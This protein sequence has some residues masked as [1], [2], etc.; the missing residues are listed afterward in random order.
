MANAALQSARELRGTADRQGVLARWRAKAKKRFFFFFHKVILKLLLVV[1]L[2]LPSS[3]SVVAMPAAS[4]SSQSDVSV[5]AAAIARKA[6]EP[7]S[8]WSTAMRRRS[9]NEAKKERTFPHP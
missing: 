4:P 1:L 7:G 3:G 8:L 5:V 9:N 6:L 2:L